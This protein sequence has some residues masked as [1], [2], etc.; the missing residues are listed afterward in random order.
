MHSSRRLSPLP[1][2]LADRPTHQRQ[3]DHPCLVSAVAVAVAAAAAAA[4][5]HE[6]RMC[7]LARFTIAQLLPSQE[8][9]TIDSIG[10]HT[11]GRKGRSTEN[12]KTILG[13]SG[14]YELECVD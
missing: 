13:K 14:M 11:R 6:K 9:A 7:S 4:S 1:V 2:I 8:A 12:H 10:G 5:G 3:Y